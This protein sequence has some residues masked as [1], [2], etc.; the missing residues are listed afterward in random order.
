MLQAKLCAYIILV[1]VLSLSST[2]AGEITGT[3]TPIMKGIKVKIDIQ[4]N[5]YETLTD[6]DGK[7]ILTVVEDGDGQLKIFYENVWIE[8]I[9]IT[10][11][12]GKS[13]RYDFIITKEGDEYAIKKR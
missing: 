5:S 11:G 12:S 4:N 13:R 1:V 8:G 3:I 2:F 6:K 10:S 7:Y 9:S